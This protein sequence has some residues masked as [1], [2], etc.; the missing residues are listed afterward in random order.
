MYNMWVLDTSILL[1]CA[2]ATDWFICDAQG[3][4]V[5]ETCE[6][7]NIVPDIL[8]CD[9][10]SYVQQWNTLRNSDH[11]VDVNTQVH[12]GYGSGEYE[13]VK[14]DIKNNLV[15]FSYANSREFF[16]CGDSFE[17]TEMMLSSVHRTMVF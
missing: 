13:V 3:N 2:D 14:C 6:A 9:M 10:Y 8:Y 17:Y 7:G 1:G 4:F 15:T 11:S 5:E 16:L 12:V